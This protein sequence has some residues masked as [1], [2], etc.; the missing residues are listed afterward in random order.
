MSRRNAST[1]GSSPADRSQTSVAATSEAPTLTGFA[2]LVRLARL[3]RLARLVGLD[4]L[5]R[6]ARLAR[7]ALCMYPPG[8][9]H[10]R[11]GLLITNL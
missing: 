2:R 6:R 3:D 9:L 11:A 7:K 1:Q 8:G 5:A 10:G 4:R